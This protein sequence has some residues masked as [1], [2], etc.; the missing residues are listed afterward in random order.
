MSS[1][2]TYTVRYSTGTSKH[3]EA[4][5]EVQIRAESIAAAARI[6]ERRVAR[7]GGVVTAVELAG[8]VFS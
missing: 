6:A 1:H 4:R 3:D 8:P 2:K 5:R 7:V